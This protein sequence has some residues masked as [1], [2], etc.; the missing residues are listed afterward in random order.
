VKGISSKSYSNP[1][2]WLGL[3]PFDAAFVVVSLL[4]GRKIDPVRILQLLAQLAILIPLHVTACRPVAKAE[5]GALKLLSGVGIRDPDEVP[6][7]SITATERL[8]RRF[9][10]IHHAGGIISVEAAPAVLD[11]ME[12]DLAPPRLPGD[13]AQSR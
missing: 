4:L 9:L 10:N 1:H 12:A 2:R 7:D 8:T 5:G 3:V 11:E 6:L 13:R